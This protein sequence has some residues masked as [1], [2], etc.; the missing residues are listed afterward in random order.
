MEDIPSAVF[1]PSLF[2]FHDVNDDNIVL[3]SRHVLLHCTCA[4]R[5]ACT[6]LGTA[7]AEV[8]SAVLGNVNASVV[9][10]AFV[11]TLRLRCLCD[12][13]ETSFLPSDDAFPLSALP[14]SV[15]VPPWPLYLV[16]PALS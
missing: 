7:V 11:H 12:G 8:G 9:G 16:L 10:G 1:V 15:S 5:E 14:F 3:T 2:L 13:A 6:A 4:D